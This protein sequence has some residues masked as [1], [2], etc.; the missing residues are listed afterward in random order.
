M[1]RIAEI[2]VKVPNPTAR[3]LY[4]SQAASVLGLQQHQVTRALREAAAK[5]KRPGGPATETAAETPPP[6]VAPAR[7]PA[8][9][10]QVVALLARYPELHRRPEAI[11]AG[12]LLVHPVLRQLHRTAAAQV[13]ETG[14][15]QIETW[16]DAAAPAERSA[17]AAAL[18]DTT[19]TEVAD[20]P[21]LLGKLANRLE[22][23]RVDAEITMNTRL[24][25]ETHARGDEEAARALA[26]RGIE[27]RKTKE[28][29]LGA[30]QRP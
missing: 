18:M 30:L 27:L 5:V 15:L 14:R 7:L 4:A 21:S 3:E 1:E 10:L 20:P 23:S 19:L 16:L 2:L 11:R 22:L 29:L 28:G 12:D 17:L 9:E 8:E 26:V 24:Q 13:A 25:R 6:P